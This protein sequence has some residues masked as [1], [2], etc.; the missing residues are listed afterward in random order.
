MRWCFST[1]PRQRRRNADPSKRARLVHLAAFLSSRRYKR[2]S[3]LR[4]KS[5]V[6]A[7]FC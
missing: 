1:N 7:T 3:N 2:V 6:M 5:E 4:Y